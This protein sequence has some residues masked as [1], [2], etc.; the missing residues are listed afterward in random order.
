MRSAE[1]RRQNEQTND[2]GQGW[3]KNGDTENEGDRQGN[4][5]GDL[6]DAVREKEGR[7]KKTVYKTRRQAG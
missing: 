3:R 5:N 2:L 1:R 4:E 6:L 7:H